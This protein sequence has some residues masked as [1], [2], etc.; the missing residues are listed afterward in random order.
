MVFSPKL[1]TAQ[2]DVEPFSSGVESLD[3]WLKRR[4]MKNQVTGASR[5]FFACRDSTCVVGYY[6]LSSSVI[7]A[8]GVPGH[9][10]CNM[11][12]PIPVVMLGRLA[13]DQ[14]FQGKGLGRAL[15]RDAGFRIIQAADTIGIRGVVVQALSIEAKTFYEKVGFA[16]SVLDP[17][18][19]IITLSDLKEALS[20]S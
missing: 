16:S 12:N 10:R 7:A 9:F 17:M 14:S 1:L 18:M 20:K 11:P 4:A 13:V 3:T 5:T 15:V 6:A 8:N 19:L 2:H